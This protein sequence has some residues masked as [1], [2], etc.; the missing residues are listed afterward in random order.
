MHK[1]PGLENGVEDGWN[2]WGTEP[3]VALSKRQEKIEAIAP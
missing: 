1:T 3:G 2:S